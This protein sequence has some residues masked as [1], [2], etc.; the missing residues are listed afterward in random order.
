MLT[1]HERQKHI[2]Y[3][4]ADND[5]FK[6]GY[7]LPT[8]T[9]WE[10]A[11][12]GKSLTTYPFGR[13]GHLLEKYAWYLRNADGATVHPVGQLKPSST[14]VFD[15]LGNVSEWCLDFYIDPET[16]RGIGAKSIYEDHGPEFFESDMSDGIRVSIGRGTTREIRGGSFSSKED[17]ARPTARYEVSTINISKEVGFRLARTYPPKKS[18]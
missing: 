10:Y 9:E 8:A 12:R 6:A 16:F 7:R 11:C 3:E 14:G 15:M 2:K 18:D 13:S 1:D 17:E 5:L 4:F